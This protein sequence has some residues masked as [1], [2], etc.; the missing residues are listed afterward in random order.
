MN[1][2]GTV[3]FCLGKIGKVCGRNSCANPSK[4]HMYGTV[5]R[6]L[7]R[8]TLMDSKCSIFSGTSILK[9]KAGQATKDGEIARVAVRSSAQIVARLP[10]LS[11]AP[12]LLMPLAVFDIILSSG[13][14]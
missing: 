3:R 4:P 5:A 14:Q 11:I 2:S 8:D 1:T 6:K 9:R 12:N 13:S 7:I 10:I